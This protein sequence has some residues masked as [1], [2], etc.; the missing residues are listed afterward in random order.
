MINDF[1][2]LQSNFKSAKQHQ[3]D[4]DKQEDIN[5]LIVSAIDDQS[6]LSTFKK[7]RNLSSDW[8]DLQYNDILNIQYQTWKFEFESFDIR[9]LPFIDINILYRRQGGMIA[10]ERTLLP[11]I[12][13]FFSV[14]EIDSDNPS[15]YHKRVNL[16]VSLYIFAYVNEI[17]QS[18]LNLFIINPRKY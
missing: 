14:G 17:Y 11:N 18:K 10:D 6:I 9:L 5:N 13:K 3:I 7:V 16:T 12:S 8:E 4:I 2:K 1:N 15:D